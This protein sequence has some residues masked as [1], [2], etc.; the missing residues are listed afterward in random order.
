M[1]KETR[2]FGYYAIIPNEIMFDENLMA[3]AKLLYGQITL[4]ANKEGNCW[5]SN[6][7]FAKKNNT[8]SQSISKWV[9][10]LADNGYIRLEYEHAGTNNVRK[11]YLISTFK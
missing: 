4:L 3:N 8:S 9:S 1:E 10:N 7:F 11:I 6:A 5:A 2:D